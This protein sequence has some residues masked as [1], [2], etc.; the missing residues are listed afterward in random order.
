M[1]N[2]D[3]ACYLVTNRHTFQDYETLVMA[4]AVWFEIMRKNVIYKW[5]AEPSK[6]KVYC[7][8]DEKVDLAYVSVSCPQLLLFFFSHN[9]FLSCPMALGLPMAR[10]LRRLLL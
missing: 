9:V 6:C 1:E 4:D 5:I 7:H 2:Q 8:D 3:R 10:T